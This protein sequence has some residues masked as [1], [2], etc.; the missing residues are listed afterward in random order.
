MKEKD[1]TQIV[2]IIDKVLMNR[3]DKSIIKTLKSEVHELAE[4]FPLY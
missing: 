3:N 2:E 1:M 4:K